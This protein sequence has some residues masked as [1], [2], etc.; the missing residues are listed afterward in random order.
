MVD[1]TV[2]FASSEWHTYRLDRL[3]GGTPDQI[4]VKSFMSKTLNY[5]YVLHT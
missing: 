3:G 1:E 5:F 4:G 2:H